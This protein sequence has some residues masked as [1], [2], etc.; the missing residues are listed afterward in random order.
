MK[1]LLI[2]IFFVFSVPFIYGAQ[3]STV[4]IQ[5]AVTY[6]T[7][8]QLK[9]VAFDSEKIEA[10]KNESSFDYLNSIDSDNWWSRFKK[11][12]QMQYQQFISW[13]FQDYKAHSIFAYLLLIVPYIIIAVILGLIVWLFIRLNPGPSLLGAQPQASVHYNEEEKIVRSQNI[14]DLIN[15]AINDGDYRL[16]VRYYYLQLLKNLNEKGVIAY[17]YQKTNSEY[18]QEVEQ[19]ELKN[20][21]KKIMRIYEFI[22]YGNFTVTQNDFFVAQT[23]FRNMESTLNNMPND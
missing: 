2:G 3:D 7:I 10:Y 5:T 9:P 12:V 15:A 16:A 14:S 8:S 20:G 17:E 21:L 22:W 4:T 11:W 6:D 1:L 19:E 18:L 13:L 23:S